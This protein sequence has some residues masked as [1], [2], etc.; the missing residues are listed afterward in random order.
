MK[1]NFYWGH[2]STDLFLLLEKT[3]KILDVEFDR[4]EL[5]NLC[6]GRTTYVSRSGDSGEV[7]FNPT[8]TANPYWFMAGGY[9]S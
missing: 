7:F 8:R 6:G 2:G 3:P 9:S 5:H 1:K 4:E